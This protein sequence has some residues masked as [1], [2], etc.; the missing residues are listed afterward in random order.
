MRC[1]PHGGHA[2]LGILDP[3]DPA[4]RQPW[5]LRLV[6]LITPSMQNAFT[7]GPRR[8]GLGIALDGRGSAARVAP[9]GNRGIMIASAYGTL[10]NGIRLSCRDA[11]LRPLTSRS[12]SPEP[13]SVWSLPRGRSGTRRPALRRCGANRWCAT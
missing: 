9:A 13:R 3:R 7:S 6:L 5:Y 4:A 10:T 2:L 1:F 12:T 8:P 11:M